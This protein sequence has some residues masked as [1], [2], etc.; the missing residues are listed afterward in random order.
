MPI[1]IN[2]V[3]SYTNLLRLAPALWP[4]STFDPPRF[5]PIEVSCRDP[6]LIVSFSTRSHRRSIGSDDRYLVRWI[7]LLRLAGRLLG[8]LGA[9]ATATLLWEESGDPSAIDEVADTAKKTC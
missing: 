4:C 8:S 7:H 3:T 5:R 1:G 9:L 6:A 2:L